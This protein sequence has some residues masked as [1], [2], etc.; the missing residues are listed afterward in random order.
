MVPEPFLDQVLA[1]LRKAGL[2]HS[3]RGPKGGHV[4]ARDP[5]T[6]SMLDVVTALEGSLSPVA[7]LDEPGDYR[8]HTHAIAQRSVWEQLRNL[9][10]D[11]L[12]SISIQQ[13]AEQENEREARSMYYI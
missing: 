4:L 1:V 13:L 12:A 9:V 6:I 10:T 7:Y 2:V 8:Q 11:Y 5:S 3:T